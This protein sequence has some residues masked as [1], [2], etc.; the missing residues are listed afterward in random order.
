M[1]ELPEVETIVRRLKGILRGKTIKQVTIHHAKSF[2]GDYRRLPGQIIGDVTRRAK[3][4]NIHLSSPFHLLIHLKMTGQLIYVD[5]KVRVG[6]GHPTADWVEAL[7]SRH[8]RLDFTFDDGSRLFFN[9]QRLFGWVRLLTNSQVVAEFAKLDPDV[10]DPFLTATRLHSAFTRRGTVL[11]QA[12]MDNTIVC[13]VGNIY[14]CDALNM[15]QLSPLRPAKSLSVVEVVRLLEAMREVITK[16]IELGGTTFDGHYV[17]VDGFAGSYQEHLL[18]Y[19]REG[20]R[21]FNCGSSIEK[22][23]LG[24]RGTYFCPR[25]QV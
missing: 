8:T 24:G 2:D 6:G 23:T 5:D 3:I 14:A 11:K 25:C 18:A 22:I 19:G 4:I 1:P 21:C 7:P 9:D 12:I 17:N 13:G 15:A 16:A 10:I 20:E